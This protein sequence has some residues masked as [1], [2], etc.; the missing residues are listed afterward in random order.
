MPL[1]FSGLLYTQKNHVAICQIYPSYMHINS[2]KRSQY[3]LN[4]NLFIYVELH[5]HI[6]KQKGNTFHLQTKILLSI[7]MEWNRAW[8]NNF[9]LY[10]ASKYF[11]GCAEGFTNKDS[12]TGFSISPMTF[13]PDL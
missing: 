3:I 13:C 4:C 10:F 5:I 2:G 1:S 12:A 9:S 8:Q 11:F 7:F 6:P